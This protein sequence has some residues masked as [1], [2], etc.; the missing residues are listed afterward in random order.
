MNSGS[1]CTNSFGDIRIGGE[2][3]IE[4]ATYL[5][6]GLHTNDNLKVSWVYFYLSSMLWVEDSAVEYGRLVI[7]PIILF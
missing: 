1:W 2:E 7:T 4:Y 3:I 6:S 5:L